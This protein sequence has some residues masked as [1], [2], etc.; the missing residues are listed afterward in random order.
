M[1]VGSDDCTAVG[2]MSV[3]YMGKEGAKSLTPTPSQA[4]EDDNAKLEQ[5]VLA[6]AS[7]VELARNKLV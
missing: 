5:C 1:C 6:S 3:N 4:Q 2:V 7:E